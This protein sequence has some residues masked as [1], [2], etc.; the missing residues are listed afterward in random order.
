[1][2][3]AKILQQTANS[4]GF[5]LERQPKPPSA[6]QDGQKKWNEALP[7]CNFVRCNF[8]RCNFVRCN[9]VRCKTPCA[10]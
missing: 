7:R 4:V 8:V 10:R 9:F 3:R 6:V 1:M 5:V 2:H